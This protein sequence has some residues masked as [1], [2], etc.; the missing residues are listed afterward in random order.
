MLSTI[1]WRAD[2]HVT[3]M[4]ELASQTTGSRPCSDAAHNDG[5]TC[6]A[7]VA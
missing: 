1:K 6:A 4:H 2:A 5:S 7:I 3:G